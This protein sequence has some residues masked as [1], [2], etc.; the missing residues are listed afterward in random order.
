MARMRNA[1]VWIDDALRMIENE[2]P[3][4]KEVVANLQIEFSTANNWVKRRDEIAQA[5]GESKE[6]RKA[7]EKEIHSKDIYGEFI[8]GTKGQAVLLRTELLY[9]KIYF[10]RA[11]VHEMMHAYCYQKENK[12]GAFYKA[13]QNGQHSDTNVQMGYNFWHEFIAETL[14]IRI[15]SKYN[16]EWEQSVVDEL[17]SD[18][19]A[20]VEN[21]ESEGVIGMFYAALLSDSRLYG[22]T[23]RKDILKT[24]TKEI[25]YDIANDFLRVY[26]LI[27]VQMEKEDILNIVPEELE[28][29]GEAITQ[30]KVEIMVKSAIKIAKKMDIYIAS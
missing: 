24:V 14:A 28:R 17:Q 30:L 26:N 9:S 21:R 7:I 11:C 15:C 1:K 27:R 8:F 19:S 4:A 13:C 23:D 5:C 25:D 22:V 3:D 2:M 20:I 16:F 10:F 29:L 12:A 6:K 18:V